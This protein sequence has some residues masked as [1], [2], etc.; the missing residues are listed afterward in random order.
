MTKST[1]ILSSR[2]DLESASG[3][4]RTAGKALLAAISRAG[5]PDT[6]FFILGDLSILTDG[7]P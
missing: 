2:D 3:C 1:D 6:T 7:T 4:I 5:L